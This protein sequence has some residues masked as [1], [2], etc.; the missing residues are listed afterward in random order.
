MGAITVQFLIF[1]TPT[2]VIQTPGHLQF[3]FW[4]PFKFPLLNPL[5]PKRYFVPLFNL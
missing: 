5:M 4:R 1:Y 3:L 2:A